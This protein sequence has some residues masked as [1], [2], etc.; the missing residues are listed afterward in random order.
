MVQGRKQEFNED[1]ALDAMMRVFWQKG[2]E[3]ASYDDLVEGTGVSRAGLYKC[4]GD[5]H[6]A[7]LNCL[8]YYVNTVIQNFTAPMREEDAG[9]QDI[10]DYF[11]WVMDT[12][13]DK[14]AY[15]CLTVNSMSEKITDQS[16]EIRDK[17]HEM[18]SMVEDS[19]I[20]AL[21]NAQIKGEINKDI[22]VKTTAHHLLGTAIGASA[23]GRGS[24]DKQMI[25]D[26]VTISM[27]RLAA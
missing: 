16:Q 25:K 10:K 4:F 19:F 9:L 6:S 8:D 22:D 7:F 12:M 21:R 20:H 5:K 15:G 14:D 18:C 3:G 13:T 2:Y 27:Q 24:I 26:F 23:M 1:E 11:A 17:I